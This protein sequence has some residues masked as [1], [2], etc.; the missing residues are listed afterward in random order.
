MT[1]GEAGHAL[2]DIQLQACLA[3]PDGVSE[4]RFL[5]D[6]KDIKYITVEPGV[7]PPDDISFEPALK[8]WLPTF[9]PGDWN[10]GHVT[11]DPIAGNAI[12]AKTTR[13]D[14]PGVESIWHSEKIDHLKL[15]WAGRMRQNI[16]LVTCSLFEYPVV[17]KFAE[18]PWQI[19]TMER[20]T[21]AYSWIHGQGIGPQFL[22]HV[23]EAGR[24]IGFLIDHTSQDVQRRLGTWISASA[25]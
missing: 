8:S 3:D 11:K 14:L 24:V 1:S 17:Y 22:G 4:Y 2:R 15:A 19:S 9:P 6:K 7:I 21:M 12:F 23:T 10:E 25:C 18:F 16:R 13:R 20:E 5:I